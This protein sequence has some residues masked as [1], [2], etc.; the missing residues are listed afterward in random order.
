MTAGI[1]SKASL[2][3]VAA[4]H[5]LAGKKLAELTQTFEAGWRDLSSSLTCND[6]DRL[7][8]QLSGDRMRI[9]GRLQRTKLG[10]LADLRKGHFYHSADADL[11]FMGRTAADVDP[12]SVDGSTD[13]GVCA[14]EE[15]TEA[16]S[17]GGRGSDSCKA[18]TDKEVLCASGGKGNDR[19]AAATLLTHHDTTTVVGV[20]RGRDSKKKG[21]DGRPEQRHIEQTGRKDKTFSSEK[22]KVTNL[23]DKILTAHHLALLSKGLGFVPVRAQQVTRLISELREWERLVRL[24]EYWSSGSRR[25]RREGGSKDDSAE[26]GS[27]SNT[28]PDL[29]YKK[30]HWTPEKGRDPWLDLYIEEV[31]RSVLAGVAKNREDNLSKKEE[32]AFMELMLDEDIVIR[33]A[34]KGSGVVVGNTKDYWDKLYREL[35]DSSTY[36]PTDGDQTQKVYKKVKLLADRLYKKGYIGKHLHRYL[37]PTLPRAGYIQGNPKLH[38]EGAPLRVIISGRGHATEGIAELAE[39]ELGPRV[40]NQ[41]SFI[42]DTT[43]FINKIKDVKLPVSG[44]RKP[45]LFLHGRQQAIP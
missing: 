8:A 26:D 36:R 35:E 11:D 32:E 15:P 3:L 6:L 43:D 17:A 45:I 14:G 22:V 7:S 12:C 4:C 41:P 39:K 20:Q 1:L 40:E 28:D 24:K 18:N 44:G 33:P 9:R 31:K 10:K 2:N 13:T 25:K 19:R 27:G 34:D 23:S 30:S 16:G 5:R 21:Q 42:R 38:K 37:I 29:R